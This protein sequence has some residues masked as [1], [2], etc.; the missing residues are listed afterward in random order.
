MT[1]EEAKRII[2]KRIKKCKHDRFYYDDEGSRGAKPAYEEALSI[3]KQINTEPAPKDKM[4]LTE[5]AHEMRKIFWFKYLA[6][7]EMFYW[8]RSHTVVFMSN[9]PLTLSVS[10][11]GGEGCPCFIHE[12]EGEDI[13]DVFSES[14][15]VCSLDL[16]EYKDENGEIDYSRCI[17][18]VEE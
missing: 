3:L 16:S 18:E 8:G 12:W 2:R 17:V 4:T 15:L 10:D 9:E 6:A 14:D 5:L 7:G 1:L 11:E 13:I